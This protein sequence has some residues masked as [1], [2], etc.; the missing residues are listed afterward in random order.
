MKIGDFVQLS[1]GKYGE[2]VGIKDSTLEVYFLEKKGVIWSYSDE[3]HTVPAS[4][5]E[6]HVVTTNILHALRDLGFRALTD[7]TFVRLDETADVPVGEAAFEIPSDDEEDDDDGFIADDDEPFTFAP[8]DSQFV[9]ETH[10]AV[11]QFNN[12][13]PEGE[14]TRVKQFIENLSTRTTH[15]ENARTRLGEALAYDRPPM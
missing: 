6:K 3:W 10:A 11:H 15:Q 13:H 14:A 2:V 7:S 8:P 4:T 12:W 5:V 9:R 1:D